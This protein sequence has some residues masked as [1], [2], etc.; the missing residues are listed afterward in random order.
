MSRRAFPT[1]ARFHRTDCGDR[2]DIVSYG[3][4][5]FNHA[6]VAYDWTDVGPITT[7]GNT[8]E[9]RAGNEQH[10]NGF[11]NDA[12]GGEFMS[13]LFGVD[14]VDCGRRHLTLP[15]SK[16]GA[17]VPDDSCATANNGR[18]EDQLFFSV[19]FPNGNRGSSIAKCAPNT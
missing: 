1:R 15:A 14:S 19:I 6:R 5:S 7:G 9:M 11:C 10:N 4:S 8:K 17:K 13:T 2:E 3:Y 18:C 12:G 16:T